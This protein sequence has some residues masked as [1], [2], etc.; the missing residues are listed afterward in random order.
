MCLKFYYNMYGEGV[1]DLRVELRESDNFI[2]NTTWSLSGDQGSDWQQASL[3]ISGY[4]YVVSIRWVSCGRLSIG[5]LY[6]YWAAWVCNS[7]VA[8]G[9]L[10]MWVYCVYWVACGVQLYIV[11]WAPCGNDLIIH[12]QVG[13]TAVR[14]RNFIGDI[15][16]D[17]IALTP[18][19]C[20][21]E[22]FEVGAA[23]SVKLGKYCNHSHV[24]N[25]L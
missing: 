25:K 10:Q 22:T 17:S 20:F 14:G 6:V 4:D 2:W 18:G 11:H 7:L 3:T 13:I 16:I 8:C 15:A 19:S 1:G 21:D 9:R 5:S 24:W 12:Q 23:E